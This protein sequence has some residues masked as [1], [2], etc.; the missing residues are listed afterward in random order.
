MDPISAHITRA[1]ASLGLSGQRILVAV[2]GGLDSSVLLH[3]LAGVAER[4]SVGVVAGHVNHGLRGSESD[5]DQ[6]AVEAQALALGLSCRVM[7]V[8]VESA[9]QGHSSR[10]RPTRQEAARKLRYEALE[11]MASALGAARIATAHH[12]DDQAETVL[13]RVI[14]GCGVDA[15]GGIPAASRG[16]LIVRPLLE[17]SRSEILAYAGAH[18]IDWRED[19]SNA[20][21]RYTRNQLRRHWIPALARAFNPQLVRTLG[22]LARSHRRDAEWIEGLVEDEF[23][24]RFRPV[25][26]TRLEVVKE[27][28]GE[29]PDALAGRLVVRALSEIGATRDLSRLHVERA[30]AFLREGPGAPGGREIELPGGLRLRRIR[31]KYVLY[32]NGP[33]IG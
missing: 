7:H 24:L 23:R 12:L 29:V 20:D 14:R 25:D 32:R 6:K 30:L 16:G 22:Q 18:E 27:G 4:C 21:D 28:W 13:M 3:A 19:S 33:E 2:S 1:V 17:A 31:E 10:T 15:L 8:D 5:G 9:R 26:G 11:T